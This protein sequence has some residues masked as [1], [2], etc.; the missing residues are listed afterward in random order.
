MLEVKN[1]NFSYNSKN[2][3]K[4]FSIKLNL[5]QICGIYWPSGSGKTTLL[6][7][8]WGLLKPDNWKVLFEDKDIYIQNFWFISFYRNTQVWYAFQNFNLLNNFDVEQNLELPF[9]I[10]TASKDIEF[11]NYLLE[12]LDIKK[13]MKKKI[14]QISGGEKERVSIAKSMIHKPK[15]LLLDEPWTYLNKDLQIKIYELMMEYFK[16]YWT[17]IFAS[18]DEGTIKYFDLKSQKNYNDLKICFR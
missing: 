8:I 6:N 17:V 4:D 5:N 15:I 13:L 10:W 7:I 12:F 16:R 14:S 9:L 3:I 2:V 18:H 11:Q 1:I